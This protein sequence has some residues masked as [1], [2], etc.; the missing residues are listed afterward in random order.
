MWRDTLKLKRRILPLLH[1]RRISSI[2][3]TKRKTPVLVD[4]RLPYVI[5]LGGDGD[6]GLSPPVSQTDPSPGRIA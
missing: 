3:A 4:A 6:E 2:P 1:P 5:E